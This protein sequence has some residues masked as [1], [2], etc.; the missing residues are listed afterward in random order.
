MSYLED[1]F[2]LEIEQ[3]LKESYKFYKHSSKRKRGLESTTLRRD[4]QVDNFINTML[5]ELDNGKENLKKRP[6]LRLQCWNATRWLGR[7]ECLISLCRSYEYISQHALLLFW[8]TSSSL[9]RP[10]SLGRPQKLTSYD[11]FLCIYMYRDL[12]GT[13]AKTTKLLQSR[14]I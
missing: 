14:D 3:L 5:R 10:R 11:A 7:S 4:K 9:R 2:V 13:M 1:Q 8:Q 12:A 6:S